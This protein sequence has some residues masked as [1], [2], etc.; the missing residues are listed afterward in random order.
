MQSRDY[1]KM[2]T[3]NKL[4]T[5]TSDQQVISGVISCAFLETTKRDC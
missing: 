3:E 5:V 1:S 2:L 4:G